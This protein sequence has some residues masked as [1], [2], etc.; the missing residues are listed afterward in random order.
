MEDQ[1]ILA[2]QARAALVVREMENKEL[3]KQK[4]VLGL[5]HVELE[6]KYH[7]VLARVEKSDAL[8][9]VV[10]LEGEPRMVSVTSGLRTGYGS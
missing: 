1:I 3:V 6:A 8:Y 5:R 2:E 4:A 9:S 7:D 10:L